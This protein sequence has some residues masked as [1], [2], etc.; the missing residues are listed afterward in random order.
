MLS[1]LSS[2]GVINLVAHLPCSRACL[3][4]H[5]S[6]GLSAFSWRGRKECSMLDMSLLGRVGGIDAN[7]LSCNV[8]LV[9][10]KL[11]GG[12]PHIMAAIALMAHSGASAGS[13]TSVRN[14]AV[15]KKHT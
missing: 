1:R 7:K 6:P 14:D 10:R 8:L 9:R 11:R 12:P 2:I 13:L 15:H 3:S 5:S 4:I